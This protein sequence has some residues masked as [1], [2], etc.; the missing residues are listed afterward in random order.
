LTK[1]IFYFC[2]SK[3]NAYHKKPYGKNHQTTFFFLLFWSIP[4]RSFSLIATRIVCAVA[5]V[6]LACMNTAFMPNPKPSLASEPR[7]MSKTITITAESELDFILVNDTGYPIKN[8]YVTAHSA[9]DWDAPV[10]S[11]RFESGETIMVKFSPRTTIK[12]YDLKVDWYD[13]DGGGSSIWER[14]YDL[15]Q[16]ESITL[17]YNKQTDVTSA[18]IK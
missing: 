10:Y 4:M 14:G 2:R 8:V 11:K 6:A 15:T 17:K 12:E 1:L 16:I 9:A 13:A 3:P 18:I 5:L 7:L